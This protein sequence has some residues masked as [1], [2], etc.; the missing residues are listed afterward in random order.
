MDAATC[1]LPGSMPAAAGPTTSVLAAA[2]RLDALLAAIQPS[3]S[4]E[5]RRL[6][7]AHYI[8]GIIK[9]CFLPHQVGASTRCARLRRWMCGLHS[10]PFHR[11]APAC[12]KHP[13]TRLAASVPAAGGGVPVWFR[14]AAGCAARWRHRHLSLHNGTSRRGRQRKQQQWQQC[15]RW[16]LVARA[17]ACRAA[18]HLGL[19]AAA[20]A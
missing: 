13:S 9:R 16:E 11:Q 12:W 3:P 2:S 17:A 18:R 6:T 8:C 10:S 4:S 14:A 15:R 20:G 1:R 5:F 19:S 7:I